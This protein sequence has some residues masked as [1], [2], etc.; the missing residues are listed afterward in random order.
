LT[1]ANVVAKMGHHQSTFHVGGKRVGDDNKGRTL[2][3]RSGGKDLGNPPWSIASAA[4]RPMLVAQSVC[5]GS[6]WAE[7]RQLPEDYPVTERWGSN[8]AAHWQSS[9]CHRGV[10]DTPASPRGGLRDLKEEGR[11]RRDAST[12]RTSHGRVGRGPWEQPLVWAGSAGALSGS[13][14]RQEPVN[15]RTREHRPGARVPKSAF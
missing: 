1:R 11:G 4:I 15:D 8:P 10:P 14:P 3:S 9:S 5:S 6:A 2:I 13:A 7:F 12:L